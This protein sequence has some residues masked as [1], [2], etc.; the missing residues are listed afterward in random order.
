[1]GSA[2]K[3]LE[4]MIR[5]VYL[6]VVVVVDLAFRSGFRF[7][8]LGCIS[9]IWHSQIQVMEFTFFFFFFSFLISGFVFLDLSLCSWCSC[10]THT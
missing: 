9:I 7:L 2:V 5:F 8:F 10:L 4:I 3:N 1:M 6:V